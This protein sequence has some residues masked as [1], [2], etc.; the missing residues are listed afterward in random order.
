MFLHLS[1]ILFRGDLGRCKPPGQTPPQADTPQ[2]ETPL[3][4]Q[5]TPGQTAS[6][7]RDGGHCSGRY[8]SYWNVF[9]LNKKAFEWNSYRP[10]THRMCFGGSYKGPQVNKFD[11]VFGLAQ[12]M[13]LREGSLYRRGRAGEF[14]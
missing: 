4:G 13:S 2:A 3:P 5:T 6:P 7:P 11:Q 1:V 8:I 9:W 14:L 12:Q 10:L